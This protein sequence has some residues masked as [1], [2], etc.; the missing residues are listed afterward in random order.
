MSKGSQEK[1]RSA[2]D[3]TLPSTVIIGFMKTTISVVVTKFIHLSKGL[4][5]GLKSS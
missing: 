4:E 1:L 2:V 3:S 5:P